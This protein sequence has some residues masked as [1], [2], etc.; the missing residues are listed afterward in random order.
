MMM[1]LPGAKQNS[2]Q[3]FFL[4]SLYLQASFSLS[5]PWR[6][7][8]VGFRFR[9]RGC[10]TSPGDVVGAGLITPRYVGT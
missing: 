9:V 2:E 5:K 8:L 7:L 4:F 10:D 3:K 6:I 1:C